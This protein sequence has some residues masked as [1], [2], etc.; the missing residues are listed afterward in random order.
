MPI[1]SRHDAP[2]G[3]S[4]LAGRV[5]SWTTK[6]LLSLIV[7]VTG[8]GVGRQTL[9][10]WR[11]EGPAQ[12][13]PLPSAEVADPDIPQVLQF[14]QS[15]WSLRRQTLQGPV[16][17]ARNTLR[18]VS[19]EAVLSAPPPPGGCKPQEAALLATLATRRPLEEQPGVW[20]LYELEG[21]L[22]VVIGVRRAGD[23]APA[24][25]DAVAPEAYR[26]VTW[27]VG[28]PIAGQ[29]WTLYTFSPSG[30]STGANGNGPAVP[31][32]PSSTP[33]VAVRSIDGGG[34][35]TFKGDSR[36]ADWADFFDLWF[37]SHKGQ[38]L[39]QWQRHG[40]LWQ[41]SFE[42]GEAGHSVSV[43]VQFGGHRDREM[44]GIVVVA[45]PSTPSDGK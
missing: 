6:G 14:G 27:S 24:R 16:A 21:N 8:L 43:F 28:V 41:A 9:H 42:L 3:L 32:P 11:Q 35:S 10:W 22:P 31:I 13:K 37:R 26:M 38:R 30:P 5:S 40:A 39:G 2:S 36:P 15:P 17:A 7:L 12:S 34:I 18:N 1:D 20:R 25:A 29:G 33:L 45:P 23:S 44:T 19:R 4:R